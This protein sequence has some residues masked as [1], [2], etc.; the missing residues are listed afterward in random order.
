MMP[1]TMNNQHHFYILITFVL[2]LLYSI[3]LLYIQ[4]SHLSY[5]I[6]SGGCSRWVCGQR[7]DAQSGYFKIEVNK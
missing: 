2:V 3:T 4:V 1:P 6:A 5:G 7:K